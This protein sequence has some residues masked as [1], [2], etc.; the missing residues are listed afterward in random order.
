[1]IYVTIYLFRLFSPRMCIL[2]ANQMKFRIVP[3]NVRDEFIPVRFLFQSNDLPLPVIHARNTNRVKTHSLSLQSGTIYARESES[4]IDVCLHRRSRKHFIFCFGR[5]AIG[6]AAVRMKRHEHTLFSFS[7][8]IIRTYEFI[9]PVRTK[10]A[11]HKHARAT[12]QILL[13]FDFIPNPQRQEQKRN[14]N[15]RKIELNKEVSKVDVIVIEVTNN[16]L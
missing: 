14:K 11:I 1:M 7:F 12:T 3:H 2:C 8:C 5:R 13:N 16:S 15:R 4:E 6:V 9:E 10:L